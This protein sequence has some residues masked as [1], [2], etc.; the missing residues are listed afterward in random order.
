MRNISQA[1]FEIDFIAIKMIDTRIEWIASSA[2]C[3]H[4][5]KLAAEK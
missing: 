1:E 3:L 4:S 2:D 5:E